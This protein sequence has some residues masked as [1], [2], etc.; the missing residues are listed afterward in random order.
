MVTIRLEDIT[1]IYVTG[2]RK[3][4]LAV[5][6]VNIVFP[7]AT[8][9]ALLG[10]S[11]CGKT[12]LLRIIAGL[13]RQTKGNV[14]FDDNEVTPLTPRERNVAMVFQFPVLYKMN[15]FENIAFPLRC[16][17][18]PEDEVRRRVRE[19]A[20][21]VGISDALN[22]DPYTLDM[23]GRQKVVLARA[24][25][26]EPTVFLFDEPLT[27]L[28]PMGRLELRGKIKEL[29]RVIKTTMIY[30]THDQAEALTL[31]DRIAVMDFGVIVQYDEPSVLYEHPKNEF[32]GYFIGNPGMNFIQGT[33]EGNFIDFGDFKY[34]V[35]DIANRLKE[36]GTEFKLGIRPEYV[37]ISREPVEG[38]FKG[39]CVVLEPLGTSTVLHIAIGGKEIK[40]KVFTMDIKGIKEG[41]E[42]YIHFPK[43]KVH[44]YSKAG[45][46][47]I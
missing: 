10:P 4:T 2:L 26:R 12:T 16:A 43:D 23:S 17:K 21:L 40:A 32:V 36:F 39:R 33:L 22:A 28:D 41:D 46:L 45:E 3:R 19:A 14:Y 37:K 1:H 44:I 27:N 5:K 20:E 6:D 34:D 9:C 29:Q 24:L 30:V 8:F 47:L 31:A 42:I 15:V 11:G 38:W 18:L 25:V 13:I 35:S 7:H